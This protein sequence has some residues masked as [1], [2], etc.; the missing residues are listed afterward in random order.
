M[1]CYK[2][3]Q[4]GAGNRLDPH[5]IDG[6]APK[7][8]SSSDKTDTVVNEGP[9]LADLR[10]KIATDAA[11]DNVSTFLTEQTKIMT[12]SMTRSGSMGKIVET[13]HK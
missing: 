4:G 5:I 3:A 9:S 10:K 7:L 13:P 11:I 1:K 6:Q 8:F 12:R 2:V